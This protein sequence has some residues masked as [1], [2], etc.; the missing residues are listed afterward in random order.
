MYR[1][2]RMT[3]VIF[4]RLQPRS[5]LLFHSLSVVSFGVSCVFYPIHVSKV[6]IANILQ[7]F[8]PYVYEKRLGASES[9]IK[10]ALEL[11]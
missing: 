1:T 3:Q 4:P 11:A 7:T 2:I 6:Y 10:N 8:Y 5:P 9:F